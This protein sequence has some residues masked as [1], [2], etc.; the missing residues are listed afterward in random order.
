MSVDSALAAFAD[1]VESDQ[2]WPRPRCPTCLLGHVRF[3][4]PV[5]S[6]S[7]SSVTARN[8]FAFEP[9]W[10]SGSFAVR[11]ECENP[12]CRQAVHGAGDY[13]VAPSRK[14]V[15]EF[16]DDRGPLPYSTYYRVR[17]LH[18]SPTLFDVPS[19]APED[20]RSSVLR[21]SRALLVDPGLAAAALRATVEVFLTTEGVGAR[22]AAG[23]FRPA[24]KRIIA[25]GGEAGGRDRVC[26]LLTAVTELGNE[27][28][29]EI[30]GLTMVDVLGG[31]ELLDHAFHEVYVA[32]SV[33]ERA[34]A[35]NDA[36]E[37]IRKDR[38]PKS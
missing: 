38:A 30:S 31:A 28:T 32:P 18:P 26:E 4:E 1:P 5:E 12:E 3:A 16:D 15:P 14:S 20:V 25:W 21:A 10:I 27:G 11:G 36:R 17:L 24:A 2:P 7:H 9:E 22:A 35:I 19:S 29:H 23:G 33:E 13:D 37:K 8:H 34:R 6:E